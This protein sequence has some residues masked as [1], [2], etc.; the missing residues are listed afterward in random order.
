[1]LQ[2]NLWTVT[3]VADELGVTTGRVRQICR[4]HGIGEILGKTRVLTDADVDR[5]RNLPDR[6]RRK[7]PK[8]G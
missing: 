8:Q 7:S 1:M 5:I 2:Q 6:R 4:A 3:E